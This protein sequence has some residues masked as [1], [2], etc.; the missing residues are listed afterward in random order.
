[1]LS[2][3][4]SGGGILLLLLS[5]FGC[6]PKNQ[7]PEDKF[8]R[9]AMLENIASSVIIP[10]YNDFQVKVNSLETSVNSFTASP[11]ATTLNSV[12][13]EFTEVYKS[14][15]YAEMFEFGPGETESQR[16]N[17]NSFPTNTAEIE[18]KLSTEASTI[19][20]EKIRNYLANLR[21]LPALDYL[22]FS[23]TQ[24]EIVAKFST[25]NTAERRK[26]YLK[27]VISDLKERSSNIVTSWNTNYKS[28][29]TADLSLSHGSPVNL[30][31]NQLN[32]QLEHLTKQKI[33][34]PLGKMSAGVTFP[35]RVE[36]YYSGISTQLAIENLKALKKAF[37]GGSGQ[38]QGLDDYLKY[39]NDIGIENGISTYVSQRFEI[40]LTTGYAVTMPLNK[41][42][43]Q[44][45]AE[46]EN[47]YL[48]LR[49]LLI[50]L[51]TDMP[52]LIGTEITYIDNDGD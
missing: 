7:T 18:N 51:K 16:L 14:W 47:F 46:V 37:H 21:G 34:L 30:Y 25:D 26:E 31:V 1:M 35:D 39:L 17:F 41:A 19:T 48:E 43:S 15:Q 52:N 6:D 23:G 49:K 40:A 27:A 20:V 24:A 45:T 10:A 50:P 33:G 42:V 28:Q 2:K 3:I 13:N 22:L 36:G 29:F 9:K 44:Q 32:Y 5:F 38:E 8:D 12:Q 11:D 4:F